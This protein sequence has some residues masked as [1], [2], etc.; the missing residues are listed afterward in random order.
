MSK[1]LR[2]NIRIQLKLIKIAIEDLWWWEWIGILLT[3][4]IAVFAIWTMA[5]FFVQKGEDDSRKNAV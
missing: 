1:G 4:V 2:D 5:N 3:I